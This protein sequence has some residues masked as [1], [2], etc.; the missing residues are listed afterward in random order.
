MHANESPRVVPSLRDTTSSMAYDLDLELEGTNFADPRIRAK[1]DES[2]VSHTSLLTGNI[3]NNYNNAPSPSSRRFVLCIDEV[4]IMR[5]RQLIPSCLFCGRVKVGKLPEW[6]IQFSQK[7]LLRLHICVMWYLVS[8]LHVPVWMPWT[9]V[10]EKRASK[11]CHDKDVVERYLR[12]LVS[13]PELHECEAL[14]SFLEV[15]ASRLES[16]LRTL[17]H[18]EGYVH[19][20]ISGSNQ[21]PLQKFCSHRMEKVY[22]HSYRIFLRIAFIASM[23]LIMWPFL[24]L[25]V[26]AVAHPSFVNEVVQSGRIIAGKNSPDLFVAIVFALGVFFV[27]AFIYKFFERRL[28]TVRR[29]AALKSNCIAFYKHRSD[30]EPSEVVLFDTQFQVAQG[31]Y[32][33]GVSWMASGLT[34]RNKGGYVEIDCGHYYTRLLSVMSLSLSFFIVITITAS[35][36]N[37][38]PVPLDQFQV[39]ERP[40][41]D[42]FRVPPSIESDLNH[43]IFCGYAF[44]VLEQPAL[45]R[46]RREGLTIMTLRRRTNPDDGTFHKVS[47][48]MDN[49]EFDILTTRVFNNYFA[50]KDTLFIAVV[51]EMR[52]DTTLRASASL[53]LPQFDTPTT[54]VGITGRF[55]RVAGEYIV[56]DNSTI[57]NSS[58]LC[59]FA[60]DVSPVTLTNYTIMIG[61][62]LVGSL[63]ASSLGLLTNYLLSFIGIWH[64]HVRRDEWLHALVDLPPQP[65]RHRFLSF[66]PKRD[67]E[68]TYK[69]M[70]EA[71]L[72]AK[73]RI[74][75]AGWWICPD[76]LLERQDPAS[77]MSLKDLLLCKAKEGV[78]IH[79]LL[80]QEVQVAMDLG[81]YYAM[82]QLRC[83]P[84]IR[85]LR[86][87]DF[88]VQSFG[89][90]S[91]HEKVIVVDF[92]VAFV[93]GL[94]LAFGRYD[95]PEHHL[96]DPGLDGMTHWWPGKDYS[97]PIIKDFVRVND[98]RE[99]LI[100][101]EHIPRMPW[102]DVHCS[103]I[104]GPVQDVAAHFIERWNFV[105]SK[106]DN[107][108]R[109]D[110]CVC[111][112]SR[113]F[114]YLPKS[115]L[116]WMPDATTVVPPSYE[117]CSLQVVRSVSSWSAGVP[118]E[119]S[120]HTAY[121]DCIRAAQHYVYIENQFFISGLEHDAVVLNRVVQALVDRIAEAVRQNHV[122]R[123][124]V[125]MPLLPGIEGNVQSKQSLTHLH[126]VMHWQ[127]ATIRT[128]LMGALAKFTSTPHDY[129]LFVG[130]RTYGVMP[131]GRCVTEQIYIHSKVLIVDDTTVICGSANINDRSMNGDRDSEI[132]VVMEDST[133]TLG[134]MNGRP[135]NQGTLATRLRLQLFQEHLGLDDP[136]VVLDPISDATWQFLHHRAQANTDLFE[137]VFRCAPSNTYRS[138]DSFD[139]QWHQLDAIYENQRLNPLR[140]LAAWSADNLLAEGD[141][142]PWTDVN[143]IPIPME[144]VH[145]DD[146]VVVPD[147]LFPLLS[148][149][150]QGWYYARNFKIF[151]DM[152]VHRSTTPRVRKRD[153][154]QH[155]MADRLLAQVRRRKYVKLSTLPVL[156]GS[157]IDMVPVLRDHDDKDSFYA[158]WRQWGS[159][160]LKP[161]AL[162]LPPALTEYHEMYDARHSAF[163]RSILLP[164]QQ[165]S[166][167]DRSSRR[168]PHLASR[169]S[170]SELDYPRSTR[171]VLRLSESDVTP[172]NA[173]PIVDPLHKEPPRSWLASI[174][175]LEMN[176]PPLFRHKRYHDDGESSNCSSY[177]FGD[178]VLSPSPSIAASIPNEAQLG[179]VHTNAE[180]QEVTAHATLQAIQG[181]I[182][183]FPL[184]F[185]VEETLKPSI[186]PSSLHI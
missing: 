143:G 170:D 162:V 14:L 94:D 157:F 51:G 3:N 53:V 82:K 93:G 176:L 55:D 45:F 77:R 5:K 153:R 163:P 121:C 183:I 184:D 54:F 12:T 78:V 156:N 57:H 27:L 140:G 111:F 139:A 155:F 16:N 50:K 149:D 84:N 21:I 31:G 124:V 71:I 136:S 8:R 44:E 13:I 74:F 123:V 118:T 95:T 66:S 41:D 49:N 10:W 102:H 160:K 61:A 182:V 85:V 29:W 146:Y 17:S 131:N 115:I 135:T 100:D 110:W 87:P 158:K 15:S 46:R 72:G 92:D 147:P 68:D 65:V 101:R 33:Q 133:F 83:H 109:T 167:D 103:I 175:S 97:N 122:F 168:R 129:V 128:N 60:V 126:A 104:G 56:T 116:P 154:F 150:D 7:E 38:K 112:R 99:N 164:Q 169:Y 145:R 107:S 152:R 105:C 165:P 76:L 119:S 62:L 159:K 81:S 114:K 20:K 186:L 26:M 179:N 30:I 144:K 11:R 86:D 166:S 39:A 142:A 75:I 151:Q 18:K 28:G 130:L 173:T 25:A 174:Q 67:Q 52:P 181:H 132:A 34:V 177:D 127:Y 23:L 171:Q 90:W 108:L 36:L 120:I 9:L 89:F 40:V 73:H 106:R 98:A 172:S 137:Q 117:P 1:T 6:T 138:F 58:V 125:V 63:V 178:E 88:Q 35:G 141:Y 59:D 24:I 134:T 42:N 70:R 48:Y 32:R 96:S 161:P 185:L 64:A 47:D 148:S 180:T 2:S 19:M 79:V 4:R 80:Y 43:P 22:R 37:Y 91:H 113:R 69:A